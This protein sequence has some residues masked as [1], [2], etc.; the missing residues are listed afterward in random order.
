MQLPVARNANQQIYAEWRQRWIDNN[1][2]WCGVGQ[3]PP[4]DWNPAVQLK[5]LG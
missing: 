1:M 3:S 2:P 4:P 5:N